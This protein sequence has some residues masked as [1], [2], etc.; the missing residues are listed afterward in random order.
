MTFRFLFAVG[1]SLSIVSVSAMGLMPRRS[2]AKASDPEIQAVLARVRHAVGWDALAAHRQAIVVS[3]AADYMGLPA[4]VTLTSGPHGEFVHAVAGRL[5]STQGYDGAVGWEIDWAGLSRKLELRD[6]ESAQIVPWIITGRWLEPNGAI[7]VRLADDAFARAGVIA[8]HLQMRAGVGHGRLELDAAT[9]RPTK[10]LWGPPGR[11]IDIRLADWRPALDFEL[12]YSIVFSEGG[13]PTR[14]DVRG[15]HE[16]SAPEGAASHPFSMPEMMPKAAWFDPAIKA[17]LEVR[18]TATGHLLVRPQIDGAVRG[19]FV[20]DSGAGSMIITPKAAGAARM[21]ALGKIA[22]NG[23]GSRSESRFRQGS[24]FQL[25][26]LTSYHPLYVEA[27][28]SFL[29]EAFG[30]EIAGFCGYDIF[31]QAVVE[32]DLEAA[33]IALHD[34][35]IYTLPEGAGH[36]AELIIHQRTPVVRA[37]F[38]GHEGAFLLDTGADGSVM[39]YAQSVASFNLLANRETTATAFEGVGGTRHA[40]TGQLSWFELGGKRFEK[41]AAQFVTD[42][43]ASADEYLQGFVGGKLLSSF[44]L[45]FDYSRRRIAFLPR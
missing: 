24:V 10:L 11:A 23:L 6:L 21:S 26:P 45:V 20:L 33:T 14:Y 1:V 7:D 31:R 44:R 28:L 2:Q 35:S 32:V 37:R 42:A 15:V 39:F 22:V 25:G 12:P 38:E 40:R 8:L 17:Q 34:P 5:S 4:G 29:S 36:W 41:T 30:V 19:W 43:G 18:R 3:A 16:V 27:D 9:W 13:I